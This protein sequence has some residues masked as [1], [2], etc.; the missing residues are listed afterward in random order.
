MCLYAGLACT[1]GMTQ[2]VLMSRSRMYDRDDSACAVKL[3]FSLLMEESWLIGQ[4]KNN[5]TMR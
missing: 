1:V 5:L 2:H 3:D 4:E